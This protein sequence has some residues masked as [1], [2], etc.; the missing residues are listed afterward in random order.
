L[1]GA[2][3]AWIDPTSAAGYTFPKATLVTQGIDPDKFFSRQTFAGGHDAAVLAVLN[4]SVDVAATFS[5][6]TQGTSGSWTQVLKDPNQIKQIRV[7]GYSKPIPGDTVSVRKGFADACPD[8]VKKVQDAIISMKYFPKTKALLRN[9]YRIDYMVPAKD[10]DYN[11][12]RD[13]QKVASGK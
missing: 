9:L 10:S 4:G 12:V 1:Q 13:V 2:R 7:V 5:N 8:V 3:I 11:V 6:N